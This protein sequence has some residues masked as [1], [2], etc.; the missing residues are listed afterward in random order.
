MHF[1]LNPKLYTELRPKVLTSKKQSIY[2]N[3]LYI[4]IHLCCILF[5]FEFRLYQGFFLNPCYSSALYGSEADAGLSGLNH[6]QIP[7]GFSYNLKVLFKL[8]PAFST[9]NNVHNTKKQQPSD[10][11]W[12]H[13]LIRFQ[14]GFQGFQKHCLPKP[15]PKKST[16]L[17][18][19]S[20]IIIPP[21]KLPHKHL[22]CQHG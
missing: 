11:D 20:M 21:Q 18:T 12:A 14:M 17:P 9:T 13:H 15:P 5:S 6:M 16:H 10:T 3:Y 1:V 4:Y 8:Q 2:I 19:V 22:R 7:L